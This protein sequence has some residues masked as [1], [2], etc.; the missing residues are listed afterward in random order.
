VAP[1]TNLGNDPF[2]PVGNPDANHL[3]PETDY[4]V[5][6]GEGRFEFHTDE[7]GSPVLDLD[8]FDP[9]PDPTPQPDVRGW[10]PSHK[11]NGPFSN[12]PPE[13]LQPNSVYRVYSTDANGNDVWHGTFYTGPDV[14]P[15]FTHIET[16]PDNTHGRVINP[17]TGDIHTMRDVHA[18]RPHG[19]PLPGT[20][21]Q[22][23][24]HTYHTDN[25]G[26]SSVSYQP[27]YGSP[28]EPRGDTRVQT[29]TGEI[30]QL[31]HGGAHRGGHSADHATQAAR[32]RLGMAPEPAGQNHHSGDPNNWAQHETNRHT[33]DRRGA[34]LGQER[35]YYDP[36][37]VGETPDR[38]HSMSERIA[39][40]GTR[41]HN[42]RSFVDVPNP[43]PV[44]PPPPPAIPATP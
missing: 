4:R 10:D 15:R 44:V 1:N 19:L 13:D 38:K 22:I 18:G 42:Y 12:T 30:G 16:W 26:N 40:D 29:R 41:T 31:D 35:I 7:N 2:T 36:P 25:F 9:P 6:T 8:R 32:G 39:P 3:L 33:I 23:G 17:E 21:Y 24:T 34:T 14:P 43:A 20:K 37:S 27:D 5:D 28:T 11:G